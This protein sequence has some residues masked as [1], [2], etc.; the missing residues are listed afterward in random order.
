[1]NTTTALAFGEE[2]VS[3]VR[4]IWE[5]HE[6]KG[7]PSILDSDTQTMCEKVWLEEIP[8]SL[9]IFLEE[10]I[11]HAD[12]EAQKQSIE[13]CDCEELEGIDEVQELTLT[14]IISLLKDRQAVVVM[15]TL[16]IHPNNTLVKGMI[17]AQGGSEHFEMTRKRKNLHNT[18]RR[19]ILVG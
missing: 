15:D 4:E 1:M 16:I 5:K 9:R 10:M 14:R 6:E 17:R 7:C 13:C 12:H 3:S 11:R 18:N 8:E 2:T 19:P